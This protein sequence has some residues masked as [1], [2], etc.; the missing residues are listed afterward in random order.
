MGEAGGRGEALVLPLSKRGE[1]RTT[2][3]QTHPQGGNEAFPLF[4][5]K[6]RAGGRETATSL[7]FP[8]AT[9]PRSLLG[10]RGSTWASEEPGRVLERGLQ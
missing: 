6:F 4:K 10:G 8:S 5:D 3:A 1:A 7:D 9:L 2:L